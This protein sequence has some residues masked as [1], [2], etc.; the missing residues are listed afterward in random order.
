MGVRI[1]DRG[2]FERLPEKRKA[3]IHHRL[4][5]AVGKCPVMAEGKN[6]KKVLK[7]IRKHRKEA[8]NIGR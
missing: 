3:K 5:C 2:E 6:V 7:A 8:H 1:W 4:Y